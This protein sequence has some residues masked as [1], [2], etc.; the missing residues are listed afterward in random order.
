MK[1][2]AIFG[3]RTTKKCSIL[4]AGISIE[5]HGMAKDYYRYNEK[6]QYDRSQ[7]TFTVRPTYTAKYSRFKS[8]YYDLRE[9]FGKLLSRVS[10]K[11]RLNRYEEESQV[12]PYE[13]KKEQQE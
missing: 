6:R 1:C 8:R 5:Y 12:K 7:D 13:K 10:I 9:R 11:Q 4:N 3:V 2:F